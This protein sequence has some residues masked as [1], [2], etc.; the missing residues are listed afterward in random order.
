MRILGDKDTR[1][2]KREGE[3]GFTLFEILVVISLVGL[4]GSMVLGTFAYILKGAAKASFLKKAND[5]G[6][7]IIDIIS[8]EIRNAGG[9]VCSKGGSACQDIDCD[10]LEIT[11]SAGASVEFACEIGG[12]GR[13]AIKKD[14]GEMI[15]SNFSVSDCGIFDC[16][17]SPQMVGVNFVLVGWDDEAEVPVEKGEGGFRT[18]FKHRAFPR[19]Y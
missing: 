9:I 16:T 11:R 10:T 18:E 5:N 6:V 13:G 1:V 15:E 17:I 8:K 19:K 3:R 12:D 7:F 4:V 14:N 2:D